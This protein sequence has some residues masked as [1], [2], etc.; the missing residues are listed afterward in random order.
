M[1]RENIRYSSPTKKC[2]EIHFFSNIIVIRI[3]KSLINFELIKR[4]PT[5]FQE[6]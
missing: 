3:K 2:G 4:E 5:H 6:L 1:K